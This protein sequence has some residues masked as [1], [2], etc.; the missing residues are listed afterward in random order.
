MLLA[1]S[2]LYRSVREMCSRGFRRFMVGSPCLLEPE[3]KQRR[4][5]KQA[6][7]DVQLYP[8]VRGLRL[9]EK[10]LNIIS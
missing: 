4:L 2:S 3:W 5:V 9:L 6:R 7:N 1:D 10:T 8:D